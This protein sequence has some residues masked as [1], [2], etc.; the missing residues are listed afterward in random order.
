MR[1][2]GQR[3]VIAVFAGAKEDEL[4]IGHAREIGAEDQ[5]E[6]LLRHHP[7]AHPEQDRARLG[8]Q[9]I[10]LLQGGLAAFLSRKLL[11]RVGRGQLGVGARIPQNRI[12]AVEDPGEPVPH[13]REGLLQPEPALGRP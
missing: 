6:P 1:Q 5:V 2:R 13:R 3:L 8:G 12:D 11:A 10:R 4:H 7:R 9:P